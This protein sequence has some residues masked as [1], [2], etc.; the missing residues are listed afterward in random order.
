MS[1]IF[2][3]LLAYFCWSLSN[4]GDK[5]LVA[6]KFKHP[7][8]YLFLSFLLSGAMLF[9][10]FVVDLG[11]PSLQLLC[12]TFLA[13]A[14]YVLTSVFYI[15]AVSIEEISR[16]N[17]LWNITPIF[18][19]SLAWILLGE[20]LSSVE[21]LAMVILL[22]GAFLASAHFQNRKT[23]LSYGL[24][25]MV[26][27][28]IFY[29]SYAVVVRHITAGTTFFTFYF[30]FTIWLMPMSLTLLLSKS[31]R[32]TFVI[33]KKSWD[34]QLLGLVLLVAI[35]ARVGVLFNQWALSQ[36]PVALVNAT[37]GFQTIF[38]FVVALLFTHFRPDIL[39]EEVDRRNILFKILGGLFLV[40][41]I[42]VLALK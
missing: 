4:L 7:F 35:I 13:A 16:I 27:A 19:L 17:M 23:T 38:V 12:F 5:I 2:L 34:Y 31:F 25:Y 26:L 42:V 9:S 3:S 14:A 8:S 10:G 41:G 30:Y 28:S 37:E 21:L 29:A 39:R 20:K 11:Q 1:W 32:T 24:V 33:E 15:K 40:A 22:M 36:G 6:N 18:S